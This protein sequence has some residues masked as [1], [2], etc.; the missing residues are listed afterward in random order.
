MMRNKNKVIV[1]VRWMFSLMII[2]RSTNSYGD[3]VVSI[4]WGGACD[5]VIEVTH[6]EALAIANAILKLVPTGD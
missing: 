5:P 2:E 4:R 6:D 1:D 3:P